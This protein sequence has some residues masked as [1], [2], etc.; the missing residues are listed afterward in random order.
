VT[1][2]STQESELVILKCHISKETPKA[3]LAD[4]ILEINGEE[5]E[6]CV[7]D[8]NKLQNQWFPLSQCEKILRNTGGLPDELHVKKWI[9]VN[10]GLVE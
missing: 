1:R 7:E 3:I 5:A 10:K 9:C 4:K 6:G 8:M 2:Y